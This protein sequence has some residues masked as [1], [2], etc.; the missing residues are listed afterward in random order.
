MSGPLAG[1]KIVDL[2]RLAPGPYATMLLGDM[3]AEIVKIDE[4]G[5]PTGRRAK[6]YQAGRGFL[7]RDARGHVFNV[8]NRNKQSLRLNLK[9]DEG[10]RIFYQLIRDADVVLE[11]FRPDVKRRLGIDYPDVAAVNPRIVYCSLTGFGQ[12]GPYRALAGHDLTYLAQTGL[13]SLIGTEASGPVIPLNVI[14]DYAAGGMQAALAVVLALFAREKTGRGQFV[15]CA[16]HDG[17]TSLLAPFFADYFESG[18]VPR[19]GST[20]LQGSA[21]FYNV[22][23][24]ADGKWL[25]V[26]AFE[27]WFYASLCQA[28]DLDEFAA[29]QW[30]EARWPALFAALRQAFRTRPRDDWWDLLRQADVAVG[31]VNDLAEAAADPQVLA[32]EMIVDFPHGTFGPIRQVGISIKLSATPGAIRSNPPVPGQHTDV[33]LGQLGYSPAEIARLRDDGVIA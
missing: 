15:D 20:L 24:C 31:K 9:N 10:R 3:G 22:Y 18:R 13:L 21:P 17:V 25:A 2:S 32:R 33:I 12:T 7:E 11:E 30:D 19:R 23:P 5:P 1:I 27:P 8:V 4:A 16:M 28:L 26:A 14:A 6:S 29:D